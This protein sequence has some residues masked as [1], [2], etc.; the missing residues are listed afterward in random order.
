MGWDGEPERVARV[1]DGL[2][3]EGLVT[4]DR[5]GTLALP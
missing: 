2:V 3:A 4:R 1:V 5:A